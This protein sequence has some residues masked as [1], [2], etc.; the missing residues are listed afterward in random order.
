[1]CPIKDFYKGLKL[2]LFISLYL[3][4]T[5]LKWL[6]VTSNHSQ[7]AKRYCKMVAQCAAVQCTLSQWSLIDNSSHTIKNRPSV[8]S[9]RKQSHTPTSNHQQGYPGKNSISYF[10]MYLSLFLLLLCY[11]FIFI[12]WLNWLNASHIYLLI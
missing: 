6:K 3:Y 5:G 9:H 8:K 1:M 2:L 11:R 12:I 7:I 4:S 10:F